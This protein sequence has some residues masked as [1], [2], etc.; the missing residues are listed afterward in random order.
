MADEK[1]TIRY[2]PLDQA[3][4]WDG[5]Y[6]RH[7]VQTIWQSIKRYG[8]KD[9]PKFEPQL[10]GGKGGIVEGNGRIKVLRMMQR[11][12]EDP[13]RG[14]AVQDGAWFVPITF[15]VDAGSEGEAEAYG[16]DHNIITVTGGD[17]DAFDISRMFDDGWIQEIAEL[18]EL[19]VSIDGDMV[20][21]LVREFNPGDIEFP[22]YDETVANDVEYLECPKCGHKW[23]K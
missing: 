13:P 14:I 12:G 5:N 23:P 20:D 8:F 10:N 22:E 1:L 4:L 19:P 18:P 21:A 3:A 6:K 15:G 16:N 9:S 11:E 17:F 2:I 7:D